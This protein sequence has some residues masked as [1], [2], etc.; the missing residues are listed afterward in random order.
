M[1]TV[2]Q[3]FFPDVKNKG[4]GVVRSQIFNLLG[5][6][7]IAALFI[8]RFSTVTE[9]NLTP[10]EFA[11]KLAL[12][13]FFIS[14]MYINYYNFGKQRGKTDEAFLSA[15][16]AFSAVANE[17][18][19]KRL[20]GGLSEF[21][22]CFIETELNN[23]RR[24]ILFNVNMDVAVY[25]EKY[26][27]M[28]NYSIMRDKTLKKREKGCIIA[29]NR[30]RASVLTM[31][32]L[33]NERGSSKKFSLGKTEAQKTGF[34][35]STKLF[36][37]VIT[38]WFFG[39]YSLRLLNGFDMAVLGEFIVQA[40]SLILAAISGYTAGYNSIIGNLKSR[41]QLRHD[42]LKM[43]LESDFCRPQSVQ[44][45]KGTFQSI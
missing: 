12:I 43:Y 39:Y 37:S 40:V 7:I 6:V 35:I 42:M 25:L 28:T 13:F 23:R 22:V 18:V 17:I 20:V 9:S 27:S 36:R 41:Y 3:S 21:C 24:R 33:L 10:A 29:A 26:A 30:Q 8:V 31:E 15:K 14:T 45:E 16:Q 32:M 44:S 2:D 1:K 19:E 5:L 34:D 11:G 4:R 38:A